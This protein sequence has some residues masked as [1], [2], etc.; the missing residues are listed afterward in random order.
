MVGY[1]FFSAASNY[2][3]DFFLFFFFYY[4]LQIDPKVAFPRR[5]QPKVSRRAMDGILARLS[6]FKPN[7]GSCWRLAFVPSG[8]QQREVKSPGERF[9]EVTLHLHVSMPLWVPSI[10]LGRGADMILRSFSGGRD[11]ACRNIYSS[12]LFIL[13]QG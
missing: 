8:C 12:I 10:Q 4:F 5:A 1:S 11:T 7:I 6:S 2:F 9:C 13:K 3:T